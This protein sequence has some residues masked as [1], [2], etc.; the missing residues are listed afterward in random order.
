[1]PT[2]PLLPVPIPFSVAEQSYIED[3]PSGL[4]PD[5]QDSNFGLHRKIF[6]DRSMDVIDQLRILNNEMFPSTSTQFLSEWEDD[7]GLPVAL[8]GRSIA[9]RQQI[10]VSRL[11]RGAFTRTGRQQIVEGYIIPTFGVAPSFG[12]QGINLQGGVPL[13]SGETDLTGTYTI[14]EDVENFSYEVRLLNTLGVDVDSLN[15]ELLR[16]TPGGISFTITLTATP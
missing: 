9:Q 3:S 11:R 1:M 16:Y 2:Q 6:C 4:W 14:L 8:P 12:S 15:R 13:H 10:A 7:L 5:N